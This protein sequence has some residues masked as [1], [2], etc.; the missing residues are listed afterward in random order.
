[1]RT[2][3]NH[4]HPL[5]HSPTYAFTHLRIHSFTHLHTMT[6]LLAPDSFKD[7]LSAE[8]IAA[9]LARGLKS[10]RP[11]C[12]CIELPL[13]DGGEG[14]SFLLSRQKGGELRELWVANPVGKRVKA[15]YGL[16]KAEKEAYI[17]LAQASGIQLLKREERN[18]LYTSTFGTGELILDAVRQGAKR[19]LL[20][21]GSSSTND[22]G[23]GM[24]EALGYTFYD[25]S[26]KRLQASGE[27]MG[28]I[29]RIEMKG[30]QI[31][32]NELEV[33]VICD[34]DNPL[35]GEKGAA[36][37]YGPQK[38]AN[39]KEVERLDEG[40]RNIAEVW[41][42][43]FAKDFSQVPGAGAAGGMGAGTM[44]FLGAELIPGGEAVMQILGLENHLQSVD[45]VITGE[46]QIDR[47]SLHGKVIK[48]VVE[49][50]QKYN[51]PVIGICGNLKASPEEV[52]EMG[53]QAAFS[54]CR[55]PGTLEDALARTEENV[56][57]MGQMLAG[58]L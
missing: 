55:G 31:D 19:I 22:A 54:I 29:H 37:V 34:V 41:K 52:R 2:S 53:L 39:P 5:T 12:R 13:A 18:P 33:K 6:I 36:K 27:A 20:G 56:W 11:D 49:K 42:N 14:T 35:F 16:N 21:I 17:E 51:V 24:A 28:H 38:G 26:G 1:M 32:L 45:W 47:Q 48:G 25:A 57:R 15:R 43:T 3:V 46:G 7:A 4:I 8:D 50:A 23:M 40:L 9:A 30:L 44:A 58:L 10:A